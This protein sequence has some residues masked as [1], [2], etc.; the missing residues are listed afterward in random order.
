MPKRIF[1][2]FIG[3]AL[4]LSFV[5]FSYIVHKDKFTQF[6]FNT[7]VIL[8]DHMPRR[9]DDLFSFFSD[10]GSFEPVLIFLIVVLI[11]RRKILA[12]I[13][14]FFLFGMFHIFELYGKFFV[15]HPPPPQFMLR[16]HHQVEF[17]QFHVRAEFSY[18]SGHSGRAL[19][20]GTILA[21]WILKSKLS[22]PW[23]VILL[24]LISIYL[25]TMLISRVYLGEHWTT[26][27]IGGAL[28]GLS[29]G[30]A[31]GWLYELNFLKKKPPVHVSKE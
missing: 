17:P 21:Y 22:L 25:V 11:L 16:T 27:V 1:P 23:K 29:F 15:D 12:G 28:L 6:D 5:L 7:T 13:G 19:F 2:L 24:G 18:P 31:S 26:D 14:T 30:I 9:F 3:I 8:Q 10:I 4:F 20:V